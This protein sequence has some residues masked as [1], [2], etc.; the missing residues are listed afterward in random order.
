MRGTR[1]ALAGFGRGDVGEDHEL[2]DQ[3]V[4]LQPLRH[5]HPIDRA[6]GFQHDLSLGHVQIERPAFVAGAEHGAIGGVEWLENR[7][8][9][10]LGHL[11][12]PA[13]DRKLRLFVMKPRGR[14][15]QHAMKRVRALAAIGAD[16]HA[17]GERRTIYVRPQ[18][19]EIVG[20]ALGQHRHDAIGKIDRVAALGGRAI[21]R[22]ARMHVMGDVGDG[23]ADNVAARIARIRIGHRVDGVV[24]ILGVGWIDGDE[25]HLAPVLAAGVRP[26]SDAGRAASASASA[27]RGKTCGMPWA[28]IAMRL[29]ARSLLSDP[30]RSTTVAGRQAEPAVA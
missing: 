21:E 26:R 29:T 15:H 30:S 27:A 25:W 4:R 19:A 13:G 23:D 8:D 3:P 12:R 28:W 6:V 1:R 22:R 7:L 20:D 24:V 9:D 10:R 11:I 14:A 18:R 2:L 16:D 17:H 5:D